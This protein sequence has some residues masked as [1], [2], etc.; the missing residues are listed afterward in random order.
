V[1]SSDA[2]LR[3]PCIQC[4]GQPL[5]S[6]LSAVADVEVGEL[7]A[8]GE[9]GHSLII[10]C[11]AGGAAQR[12]VRSIAVYTTWLWTVQRVFQLLLYISSWPLIHR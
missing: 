10:D 9:T 2:D 8:V 1:A 12:S 11:V 3:H 4:S 5:V 7:V 6:H